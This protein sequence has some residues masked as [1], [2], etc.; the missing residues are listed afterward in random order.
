MQELLGL[1]RKTSDRKPKRIIPFCR[2]RDVTQPLGPFGK[3][4]VWRW[5][6]QG[7]LKAIRVDRITLIEIAS[8]RALLAKADKWTP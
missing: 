3:A 1:L 7:R 4:T 2:I 5:I 8:I 6:R